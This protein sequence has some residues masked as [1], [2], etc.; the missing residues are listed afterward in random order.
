MPKPIGEKEAQRRALREDQAAKR[1][2][3]RVL[4]EAGL[5]ASKGWKE[6][7]QDR[8]GDPNAKAARVEPAAPH[9]AKPPVTLAA[10]GAKPKP[11]RKR[12]KSMGQSKFDRNAYQR[13]YMRKRRAAE[14]AAKK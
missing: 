10:Q 7:V 1:I 8:N 11:K 14:K 2:A 12:A 6:V 4:L 5:S 3:R 9:K 13:E